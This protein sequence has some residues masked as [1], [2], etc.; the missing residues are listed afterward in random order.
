MLAAKCSHKMGKY[1]D[2][3][4]LCEQ[5]YKDISFS[6]DAYLHSAMSY[7]ALKETEKSLEAIRNSMQ[8]KT[9]N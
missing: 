7:L 4:K 3:I 9:T 8:R 5:L 6:Y 1:K 2:T